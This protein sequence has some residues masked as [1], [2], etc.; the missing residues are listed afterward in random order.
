MLNALSAE[1]LKLT[2]HKATWFLVWIYPAGLVFIFTLMISGNLV[3]DNSP[4]QPEL[5]KWL[6]ETAI[7]WGAPGN[8]LGRYLLAAFVAVVFAGEYGWNTWKLIVPHRA[9]GSLVAAKYL[10][11][12]LL[13]LAT[14]T[15]AA[16]ITVIGQIL[17]DVLSGD[18]LPAGI[19]LGALLKV[20]GQAAL[21]S[22]APGLLAIAYASLASILTRSTIAALVIS[23]VAVTVEQLLFNFAPVLSM[24]APGLVWALTHILP[25]YHIANIGNWIATGAALPFPLPGNASTVSLSWGTSAAAAAAWIGGLAALTFL[26]FR[27]QDLN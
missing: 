3:S 1:L 27:R 11:I 18:T 5:G 13:F 26:S 6:E 16:I 19:T 4:S 8:T 17:E 21:S 2:R 10:A 7:V 22:L 25:G 9:R 20:H 14:F 15:L 23:I 24:K 12:L